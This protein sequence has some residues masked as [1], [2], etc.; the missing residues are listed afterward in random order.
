MVMGPASYHSQSRLSHPVS[1]ES[2]LRTII[3]I[4]PILQMKE[5]AY[6]TKAIKQRSQDWCL[7]NPRAS[8][9]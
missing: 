5:E 4:I 2:Y 7:Q 9:L 6:I 8:R 3:M 1:K